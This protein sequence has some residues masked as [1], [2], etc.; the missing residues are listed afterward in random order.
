MMM[1][2]EWP[3]NV[4]ELANAIEHAVV[5]GSGEE[6][7]ATDLPSRLAGESVPAAMDSLGAYNK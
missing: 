7:K 3:D 2:C 1:A 4:R 6:V 5:L